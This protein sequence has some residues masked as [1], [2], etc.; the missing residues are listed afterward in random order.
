[1]AARAITIYRL[2]EEILAILSGGDL[3]AASNVTLGDLKISICQVINQ[4]LKTD[5]IQSNLQAREIIP[6]GSVIATYDNPALSVSAYGVGR[7]KVT[8]PVKPIK[9]PRNMGL[10]S[11]YRVNASQDE[12]I[13]LQ[14]GQ[15]SLL[16]SQPLINDMLGQVAYE[17]FGLDIIFNKD[18]TLLYPGESVAVRLM[19][20]DVTQYGDY[21]ILPV[22]PEMEWTIKQE[23]LKLYGAEGTTDLLVDSS[24]KQ[25][26]NT[27][28]KDQKQQ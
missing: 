14:M 19:I 16:Q 13:P 27:P 20:M 17:N 28:V 3:Q 15:Q 11:V 9:L 18:L 22:L 12:F 21:D 2:S 1:M 8:L 23:V 7:S 4:L 25:Q 10:W 24:T 26:Q 6:N 5:Y